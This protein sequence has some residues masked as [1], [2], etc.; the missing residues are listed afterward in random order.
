MSAAAYLQKNLQNLNTTSGQDYTKPQIPNPCDSVAQPRWAN[1]T[2]Q[3]HKSGLW[4]YGVS[5]KFSWNMLAQG[6]CT[7]ASN[8][9]RC[10][11]GLHL[12]YHFLQ[13]IDLRTVTRQGLTHFCWWWF[14]AAKTLWILHAEL[15]Q[16]PIDRI[17]IHK[18]NQWWV[19]KPIPANIPR[20]AAK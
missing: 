3:Q 19:P 12:P 10:L 4:D 14:A 6:F 7:S 15:L 9:S 2:Q 16:L 17:S 18:P 8:L 5:T 13:S 20:Q 1:A 11:F